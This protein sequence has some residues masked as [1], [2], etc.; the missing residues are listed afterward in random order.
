MYLTDD[1]YGMRLRGRGIVS[2]AFEVELEIVIERTH[3]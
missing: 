2:M 3:F 1:V